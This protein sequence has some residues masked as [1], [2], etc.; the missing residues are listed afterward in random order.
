MNRS[1]D[2]EALSDAVRSA[3][4][5]LDNGE[6]MWPYE[7]AADAVNALAD[8]GHV[9]LGVDA[10]ERRSADTHEVPISS[11][12]PSGEDDVEQ[13]RQSAVAAVHRAEAVSGWTQPH[14]L[15]TWR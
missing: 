10:R 8:G 9:L 6:V 14:L 5:W 13:G 4:I 12:M 2:I 1:D 7:D 15:L 11:Y 3:A